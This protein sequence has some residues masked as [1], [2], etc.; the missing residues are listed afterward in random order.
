M[1][2][3]IKG[4]GRIHQI[5]QHDQ[6]TQDTGV[7]VERIND[8]VS[9]QLSIYPFVR[10]GLPRLEIRDSKTPTDIIS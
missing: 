9:S 7:H 1:R 4:I 5:P 3:V 2:D 8:A 6:V 10:V